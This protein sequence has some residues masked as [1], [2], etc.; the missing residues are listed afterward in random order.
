V[1]YSNGRNE[2]IF[3]NHLTRKIRWDAF[4]ESGKWYSGGFAY[5]DP[6]NNYF[7]DDCLLNDIDLTQDQLQHGSINNFNIVV[8]DLDDDGKFIKRIIFK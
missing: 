8:S 5:V 1:G 4:K 3:V 7:S 2:E 6:D